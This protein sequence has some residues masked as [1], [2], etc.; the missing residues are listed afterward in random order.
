MGSAAQPLSDGVQI[1][2]RIPV[3]LV[4]VAGVVLA[5]V[6]IRRVGVAAGILGAAGSLFIGID[7]LVNVVWVLHIASLV[8]SSSS[9]ADEI[10][11]L[12]NTYTL[13]DCALVTLGVALVVAS[14]AFRKSAPAPAAPAAQFP[15]NPYATPQPP[16]P[17][18]P[19]DPSVYQRP[20]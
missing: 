10:T 14:F 13:V 8:K 6:M 2:I 12:S 3:I 11:T 18:F 19:P 5:L 20:Q 1:G 17:P 16:I 9:S 15:V 7:Q 4:A